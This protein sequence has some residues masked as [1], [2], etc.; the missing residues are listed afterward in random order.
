MPLEN[1]RGRRNRG[2]RTHATVAGAVGGA[3]AGSAASSLLP[4]PA[5]IVIDNAKTAPRLSTLRGR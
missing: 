3:G 2:C 1:R 4:Q 5:S